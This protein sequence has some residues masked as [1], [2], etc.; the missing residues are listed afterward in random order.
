M[1][2]A[3]ITDIERL[4]YY[5]GEFLGA[6]DFQAEQEYHR[7]MRRRHNLGQH[8]WG[9]VSGLDLVQI[10]NNTNAPD[11]KPAVDIYVQPGMAVDAFGREILAL[12]KT[13]L[14]PDLFAPYV[15][16]NNPASQPMYIWISYAQ[17]MLQPPT[18]P[19]TN[20]NQPNAF[21]R[22][23]EAFALTV[24]KDSTGPTNDLIIVDGKAVAPPVLPGDIVFPADE[25]I[26]YQEFS[27]DDSTVNWYILLG[28]VLW[29]PASGVFEQTDD[30]TAA[31]GREYVGNVT[32]AIFSPDNHL[33]IQDRFISSL[34]TDLKGPNKQIYGGV[35]VEVVGSLTVDRL[36]EAKQNV[37]IDGTQDLTNTTLSPLTIN[38][39]SADQSFIQ[40]RDSS[41]TP[42]WS[43]WETPANGTKIP[44]AGLSFGDVGSTN[45]TLFI[46]T[47]ANVGIGTPSPTQKLSV[48]AG[49]NIDQPGVN[50]GSSLNPGLSFGSGATEGIAS[51]QSGKPKTPNAFGLDFY[52]AGQPQLS[53][54]NNGNVGI[55]TQ[56]PQVS[57]DV[58][59]DGLLH[60]AGNNNFPV[61]VPA[62][63]GAYLGWNGL[64][65][66][67]GET[68]FINNQ[69]LG[70]GGFAFFN[71]DKSG[72]LATTLMVVTGSGGLGIDQADQNPGLTLAPGLTFGSGSGEGIASCRVPG[73]NRYGL[74]FYSNFAV[75]M[76][77]TNAG[78]VGVANDFSVGTNLTVNGSRTYL[79][80]QDG[81]L[82]HWIMGGGT[83][84]TVNNAIALSFDSF[85]KKGS[86][87]VGNNWTLHAAQKVGY[88]ADR[89]ISRTQLERGEVVVL[90]PHTASPHY[91]SDARIPLPEV[92]STDKECDTR[93]CG[94]VDEPVASPSVLRDLDPAALGGASVGIMVTV[95]AYAHCKADATSAPISPGDLL[96]TS[97]TPGHVQKAPAT[98]ATQAGAII[99]KALGS[100]KK[101]KGIIPILVSHQ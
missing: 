61:R 23:Q 25:S 54:K 1:A 99:G 64:T 69:G 35:G 33:R 53:I 82:N 79:I 96:T 80:G 95:G 26:P 56:D 19:C 32:S 22:V 58:A 73:L 21:G 91:G 31:T 42:L 17:L 50:N 98:G 44:A 77:I 65:G 70:S 55:G 20:A 15:D 27:T 68:D 6:V 93:V 40:F 100:L 94:I 12:A 84:E 81:A 5:E 72:A 63:Q 47:G 14:T 89:F 66:G 67:T 57:L 48:N 41:G 9:I 11:G 13:Q 92:Q 10:P 34:P 88:L 4:N 24:T 45:P 74:D 85:S 2:M 7:D 28:Q 97:S 39:S 8:T 52:T 51:N 36:L 75:R 43:I 18:D 76:S 87:V 83:L 3:N 49:L 38:A 62:S 16:M 59:S 78:H 30:S 29:Y 71:T 37:L 86:I 101:G 46:Q 60:V 90:H